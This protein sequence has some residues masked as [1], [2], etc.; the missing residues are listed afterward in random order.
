MSEGSPQFLYETGERSVRHKRLRPQALVQVCLPNYGWGRFKQDAKKIE[1]LGRQM[2]HGPVLTENLT[3]RC[4]KRERAKPCDHPY[5]SS[6]KSITSIA[7]QPLLPESR[8]N[9]YKI[10][11]STILYTGR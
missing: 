5:S 3:P 6:T 1:C 4:V 2:E 10:P 11:R 9:P 8:A 7:P